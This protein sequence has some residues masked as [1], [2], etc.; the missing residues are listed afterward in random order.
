M[1]LIAESAE[2]FKSVIP[3]LTCFNGGFGICL[4]TI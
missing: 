2:L 3:T 1:F 4:D